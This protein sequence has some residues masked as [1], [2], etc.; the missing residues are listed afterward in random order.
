[1]RITLRVLRTTSQDAGG[2]EDENLRPGD[3]GPDTRR[4]EEEQ[5]NDGD[6]DRQKQQQGDKEKWR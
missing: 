3:E 1:M 6:K 2:K 4:M 5:K